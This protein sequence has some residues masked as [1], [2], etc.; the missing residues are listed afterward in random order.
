MMKLV[1]RLLIIA[2]IAFGT[3]FLVQHWDSVEA[4]IVEDEGGEV[5]FEVPEGEEELVLDLD[6]DL[7][8]EEQLDA[9]RTKTTLVPAREERKVVPAAQQEPDT[10]EEERVEDET[11][12]ENVSEKNSSVIVY[13]FDGGIDISNS[14]IPEGTVSFLVRNDGRLSHDFSIEGKDDFGR[15]VPGESKTFVVDLSAGEYEIFSPRDIDQKLDMSETL[16]VEISE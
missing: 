1:N 7:S 8:L 4:P 14:I 5:V 13:L 3:W 16:F 6:S 10:V 2:V 9:L 11:V 12:V 15:I